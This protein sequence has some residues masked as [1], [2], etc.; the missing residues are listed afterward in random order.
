VN[1]SPVSRHRSLAYVEDYHVSYTLPPDTLAPPGAPLAFQ[2]QLS[3]GA[4][5]VQLCVPRISSAAVT[6]RVALVAVRP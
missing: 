5:S 1:N 4:S 6:S 2:V 3:Y